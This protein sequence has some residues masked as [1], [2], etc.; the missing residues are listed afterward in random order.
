MIMSLASKSLRRVLPL[1]ACDAC[2]LTSTRWT[3]FATPN[4]T[5]DI[6]SGVDLL[7][8]P[9]YHPRIPFIFIIVQSSG[10]CTDQRFKS[11]EPV[12]PDERRLFN[13]CVALYD[14]VIKYF[15][16]RP[17]IYQVH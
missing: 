7:I 4:R 5:W 1:A 12:L 8:T 15:T 16:Q 3:Y 13:G 10:R 17:H 9:T 11:T 2:E 6:L 14:G